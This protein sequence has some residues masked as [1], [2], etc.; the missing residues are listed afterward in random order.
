MFLFFQN[1]NFFYS[2]FFPTKINLFSYNLTHHVHRYPQ[3]Q[4]LKLSYIAFLTDFTK[5][6]GIAYEQ[7]LHLEIGG[8][9]SLDAQYIICKLRNTI[10]QEEDI[11]TD[12]QSE[13]TSSS[14]KDT[15]TGT[16]GARGRRK[17]V[18]KVP[19]LLRDR[20]L[21]ELYRLLEKVT[22]E[23]MYFWQSIEEENPPISKLYSSLKKAQVCIGSTLSFWSKNERYFNAI[24]PAQEIYGRFLIEVIHQ[25]VAGLRIVKAALMKVKKISEYKTEVK[26]V[27]FLENLVGM[28]TPCLI[29]R[30]TKNVKFFH[31]F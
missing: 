4:I 19:K 24:M 26:N 13:A 18:L 7:L 15:Q 1:L 21:T 9:D 11:P 29:L 3:D 16:S 8:I 23:Y 25:K 27:D 5:K 12:Q 10:D 14:L 2:P 22:T 28:Q 31:F 30:R 17:G 20:L 6:R